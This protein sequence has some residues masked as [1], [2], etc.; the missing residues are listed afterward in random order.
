MTTFD[1]LRIFNIKMTIFSLYQPGF[2]VCRIVRRLKFENLTNKNNVVDSWAHERVLKTFAWTSMNESSRWI[3]RT[4]TQTYHVFTVI[5]AL[6][7]SSNQLHRC[8]YILFVCVCERVYCWSPMAS[9]YVH[10]I[11]G[12]EWLYI[13]RLFVS[14][15]DGKNNQKEMSNDERTKPIASHNNKLYNQHIICMSGLH[16]LDANIH[17]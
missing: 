8:V 13:C 6:L 16:V 12:N 14:S 1:L 2:V 17:F 11:V 3:H 5:E 7:A 9:I 10:C 4:H 15:N